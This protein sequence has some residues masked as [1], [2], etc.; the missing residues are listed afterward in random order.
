[1][2]DFYLIRIGQSLWEQ[3]D[4]VEPSAGTPLTEQ[5]VAEIQASGAQL[6]D[7][8]IA[9]VYA[10]AGEAEVKSAQMLA[11]A[12]GVKVRHD[13]N[14]R[15]LDFGLWQGLT[16]E[17]LHRRHPK[18]YRQWMES[19]SSV[20]PPGGEEIPEAVKRLKAVLKSILKRHKDQSVLI[21]LRPVAMGL[22]RCV[23]QGRQADELWNNVEQGGVWRSYQ[24]DRINL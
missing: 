15:E 24:A 3:Q 17:E 11:E 4:R 6:A 5:G 2:A 13:D 9:V 10:D 21:V 19:P 23:L 20:C 7:K 8:N 22:L 16:T 14:L 12:L 18:V 1:M